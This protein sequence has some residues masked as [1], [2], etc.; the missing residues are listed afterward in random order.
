MLRVRPFNA[1]F[2]P[3]TDPDSQVT[4]NRDLTPGPS[5]PTT[6]DVLVD[7]TH[8]VTPAARPRTILGQRARGPLGYDR[9][10]ME[11]G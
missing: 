2:V 10:A 4:R 5:R 7:S 1:K 8:F 9:R 11:T 6:P 3:R